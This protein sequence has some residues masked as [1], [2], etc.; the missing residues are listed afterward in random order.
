[1]HL[2]FWRSVDSNPTHPSNVPVILTSVSMGKQKY[3]VF[4]FNSETLFP[5]SILLV[6]NKKAKINNKSSNKSREMEV[7]VLCQ[8]A[9][10][11]Q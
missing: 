7:L 9:S 10:L 1:M 5:I 2:I 8:V 11:K 4:H 6:Y 3:L